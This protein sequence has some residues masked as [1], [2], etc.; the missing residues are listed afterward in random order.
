[1]GAVHV[2]FPE[3]A[4]SELAQVEG[5]KGWG[6]L[7]WLEPAYE[8]GQGFFNGFSRGWNSGAHRH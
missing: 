8:F 4:E 5:G 2:N 3:L 6:W 7:P 1:M